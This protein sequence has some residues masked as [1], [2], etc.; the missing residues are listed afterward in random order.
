MNKL[1]LLAV[2]VSL[3]GCMLLTGNK[4]ETK[5]PKTGEK[6]TTYDEAPIVGVAELIGGLLGVGT[7]AGAAAKLARNAARARDGLMDAN[8][9]AIEN[10][11]WS[12][13]DSAESFKTLLAMAQDSHEDAKLIRKQ[14][15]KWKE[16]KKVKDT[17]N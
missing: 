12:K 14:Y 7:L 15:V 10:A 1:L 11:D 6:K 9:E 8:E 3:I 16:T 2:S 17:L 5:D 13:I 4:T